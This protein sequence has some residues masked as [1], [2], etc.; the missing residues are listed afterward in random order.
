MVENALHEFR[1]QDMEEEWTKVAETKPSTERSSF[2]AKSP[3]KIPSDS[4]LHE[5]LHRSNR[6][7]CTSSCRNRCEKPVSNG[8]CSI[9]DTEFDKSSE[10]GSSLSRHSID[11]Y[12]HR[13][14]HSS[15]LSI[16]L[17]DPVNAYYGKDLDYRSYP[18]SDNSRHY[19][20]NMASRIA[21]TA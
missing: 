16:S 12:R 20:K 21:R 14:R 7:R 13:S 4:D 2:H 6:R 5:E 15:K 11:S 17:I 8:C 3:S 18:F 9:Y 19:N 1:L 10:H